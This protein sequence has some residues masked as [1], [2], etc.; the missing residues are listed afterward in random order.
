LAV[1]PTGSNIVAGVLTFDA[2]NSYFSLY[3]ALGGGSPTQTVNAESV[4]P[5]DQ[6]I[7]LPFPI[8]WI[9]A[10]PVAM[11][12]SRLTTQNAWLGGTLQVL[13]FTPG[14]VQ[15]T[16]VG[17]ADC[18][19]ASITPS[20]LIPC[21]SSNGVVSVRDTT[22]KVIWTTQVVGFNALLLLLSPDG[23]AIPD[24][25]RASSD[26]GATWYMVIETRARGDIQMPKGFRVEGWLD[27]NTVIGAVTP[28]GSGDEG[29]LAW[30]SLDEPTTVHDLG[31]K[32]NFVATLT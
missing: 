24:V 26:G 9:A 23:Q 27:S 2:T 1:S 28:P 30:V 32:G 11:Y 3:T 13:T 18:Q 19:S 20:G 17:G 16:A 14:G 22:G 12:P 8:G 15:G 25:N 6:M 21:I 5:P 29:N 10:G 31:F 4:G 7:N